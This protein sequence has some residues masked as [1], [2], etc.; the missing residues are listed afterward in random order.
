MVLRRFTESVPR[1]T[2]RHTRLSVDT[3]FF[4]L[5]VVFCEYNE[6]NMWQFTGKN[7]SIDRSVTTRQ[8]EYNR[9]KQEFNDANEYLPDLVKVSRLWF[10]ML[11]G[12]KS[13][14]KIR[15][16]KNCGYENHIKAMV[17]LF[18]HFLTQSNAKR[19]GFEEWKKYWI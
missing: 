3:V 11:T 10:S 7:A 12:R 4:F 5:L 15:V 2:P 9:K 6:V 16:R 1:H 19:F 14:E 8:R 13:P 17:N 18:C